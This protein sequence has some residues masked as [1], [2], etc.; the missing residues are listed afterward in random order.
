MNPKAEGKDRYS[1]VYV[2]PAEWQAF[3]APAFAF[4]RAN[5][6]LFIDTDARLTAARRTQLT[7]LLTSPNPYLAAFACRTLTKAG[8]VDA[9]TVD[10]ALLQA[11]PF[12][13]AMMTYLLL[14][15]VPEMDNATALVVE[16]SIHAITNGAATLD[17]LH[18]I[19]L[20]TE[21]ALITVG[22]TA[23]W[24]ARDDLAEVQKRLAPDG[25]ADTYISALLR[26]HERTD[27]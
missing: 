8:A 1:P 4:C 27:K 22:G 23:T 19:A 6:T 16:S 21:A 9:E 14:A 26:G 24:G 2:V 25:A 5:S 11:D 10:R 12:R 20:G 3:V 13:Q 17:S 15:N 7:T 18:G